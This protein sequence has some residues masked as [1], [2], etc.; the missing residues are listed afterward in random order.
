M[1]KLV[2]LFAGLFILYSCKSERDPFDGIEALK[3]GSFD[4]ELYILNGDTLYLR[5]QN[6]N[7][8]H[9]DYFHV[10][11]YRTKE[12]SVTVSLSISSKTENYPGALSQMYSDFKEIDGGATWS[13]A[14]NSADDY[15]GRIE[16]DIFYQWQSSRAMGSLLLPK[17]YSFKEA[18][19]PKLNGIRI[20]AK[21]Q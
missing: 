11:I 7:K 4:V 16:N 19:D 17:G 2:L 3:V 13:S 10:T 14:Y 8:L 18:E 9:A 15:Q 5:Q 12:D 20:V 1:K 21:K 6:I